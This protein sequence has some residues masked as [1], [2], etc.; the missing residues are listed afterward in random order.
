MPSLNN[1]C[2]TEHIVVVMWK[3][4]DYIVIFRVTTTFGTSFNIQHSS[5]LHSNIHI[6]CIYRKWKYHIM[7]SLA[8]YIHN[9]EN[10]IDLGPTARRQTT[11]QTL[12]LWVI[13][14]QITHFFF[15]LFFFKNTVYFTCKATVKLNISDFASIWWSQKQPIHSTIVSYFNKQQLSESFEWCCNPPNNNLYV[16]T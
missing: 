1:P 7:F 16:V 9:A 15:F 2:K 8:V 6:Y 12:F 13:L 10:N 3:C 14:F 5:F 11:F 4:K